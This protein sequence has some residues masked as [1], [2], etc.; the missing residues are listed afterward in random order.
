MYGTSWSPVIPAFFADCLLSRRGNVVA[1]ASVSRNYRFPTLNDLYFLPGGNPG[2]NSEKGV[3]YEAGL[4]F[5]GK[6][7]RVLLSGSASWVRPAHRLT[8]SLVA[9]DGKGIF[10]A[11]TVST[12]TAWRS[13]PTL[14]ASLP[15]NWKNQPERQGNL[16]A[17]AVDQRG[18]A[19]V[20][21]RPV[22]RQTAAL[23]TGI[24]GHGDRKAL[25]AQL[26]PALSVLLLQRTLHHVEQRHH[27]HRTPYALSD[28]QPLARKGSLAPVGGPDAQRH[29]QQPVQRGVPLG[30]L[31]AHAAHERRILHRH[32]SP[33]WGRKRGDRAKEPFSASY[34]P[35]GPAGRHRSQRGTLALFRG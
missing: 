29:G 23:R 24:F 8:G 35:S 20:P 1:K 32:K 10:L 6:G 9:A 21:G 3:A 19:D 27:A 5:A 15:G 2:L 18:G 25:L 4:S 17:G 22:G 11:V 16:L 26:G 30:A 28:E 31:P 34:F 13:G 12:L 33:K 14:A 7:G